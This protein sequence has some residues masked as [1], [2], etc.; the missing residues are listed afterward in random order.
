MTEYGLAPINSDPKFNVEAT[1][2]AVGTSRWLAPEMINPSRDANGMLVVESKPADIF[3]FAM[4]VVEVFT[5]KIP[6]GEE[7]NEA[8]VLR[9]SQGGRPEMPENARAVGLT[10]DIWKLL[11]SCWQQDT[12][13]RPTIEEVMRKW[14]KFVDDDAVA[15]CV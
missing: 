9:I 4:V 11:E 2:G 6:F 7:K 12:R 10:R 5:G 1:P 8:V 15:G 3:A 13:K 14:Q